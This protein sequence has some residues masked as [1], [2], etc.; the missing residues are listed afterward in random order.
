[1]IIKHCFI[2][3]FIYDKIFPSKKMLEYNWLS[4]DKTVVLLK[5]F[6]LSAL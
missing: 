1:M 4:L 5:T 6:Y 3:R 2:V